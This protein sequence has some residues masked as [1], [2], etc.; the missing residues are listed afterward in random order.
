MTEC[1]VML[2]L[3]RALL[4][5]DTDRSSRTPVHYAASSGNTETVS[6][7][8]HSLTNEQ[9]YSLLQITDEDYRTPVHYTAIN[10]K[11]ETVSALTHSLTNEQWYS[12]LMTKDKSNITPVHA[13]AGGVH[14]HDMLSALKE[15]V[16]PE[17]WIDLLSIPWPNL[18]YQGDII[19]RNFSKS[20][21]GRY[22][23]EQTLIDAKVGQVVL[24]GNASEDAFRWQTELVEQHPLNREHIKKLSPHCTSYIIPYNQV[25]SRRLAF[26][27]YSSVQRRG[28]AEE[29]GKL[30]ESLHTAG[31]EVSNLEWSEAIELH[32]LIDNTLI[33]RINDC[34]LLIVCIMAH[35]SRGEIKGRSGK[36]V[37]VNDILHQLN[38]N[39]PKDVP[40]VSNIMLHKSEAIT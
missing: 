2:N 16:T 7:L 5:S 4:L 27:F 20:P 17:Q 39:L 37:P 10:M 26:I 6:G 3:W 21:T 34:S 9:W 23:L 40:M 12:L 14:G 29:A 30:E 18:T 8:T 1:L 33:G 36:G 11:T 19:A 31:C 28:A 32:N 15:T 25:N 38:F 22:L 24:A 35:G 13:A